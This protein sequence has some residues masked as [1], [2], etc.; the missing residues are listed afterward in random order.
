MANAIERETHRAVDAV[1][2]TAEKA[3]GTA[4]E[5]LQRANGVSSDSLSVVASSEQALHN[6]Q[7]VGTAAEG[8]TTSIRDIAAEV[9]RAATLTKS[10]VDS[11]HK[12]QTTIRAL[13]EAVSKISEVAKLIGQ[14]AG[15]TNLL[16]LN[17]TIEAARAGDAGKGFAV[18]ASEVKNL[19]N[20][21]GRSTEDIDRQIASIRAETD[22]AVAA[23]AEIGN[24]IDDISKVADAIAHAV[25]VQNASTEEITRNV[26]ET[27]EAV[28]E[29]STKIGGISRAAEAVGG[30]VADIRSTLQNANRNVADLRENLTRV[31][32]SAAEDAMFS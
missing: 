8:M 20:Q 25:E 4:G 19:A 2:A 17:A 29:V 6:V 14:I 32:R 27:I 13:S 15:Q 24:R 30:G 3:D 5:L 21:T 26:G 28:R 7:A 23:V 31:V 18:V 9:A 10:A 1:A 11:G 12:A 16:A 22:A